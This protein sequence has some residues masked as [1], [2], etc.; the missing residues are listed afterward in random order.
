MSKIDREQ[1]AAYRERWVMVTQQ[2]AAEL[3]ELPLESKFRQLSALFASRQ[4]FPRDP[5]DERESAVVR[6]R[7]TRIRAAYRE[8]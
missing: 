3:R 8:R 2:E 7:W 4:L 6:E 5:R 1:A